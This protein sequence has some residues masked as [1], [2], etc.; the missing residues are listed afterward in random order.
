M[1]I[2]RS[3]LPGTEG[4]LWLCGRDDIARDPDAALAY[5][6]GASTAVCLLPVLE[7]VTRFPTFVDCLRAKMP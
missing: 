2:D 7:V 4:A 1:S 6:D 5:A 3:P